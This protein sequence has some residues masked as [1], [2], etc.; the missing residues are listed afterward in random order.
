VLEIVFEFLGEESL[1]ES[2][3]VVEVPELARHHRFL[4]SYLAQHRRFALYRHGG[5]ITVLSVFATVLSAR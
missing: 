4:E 2:L 5:S 1:E 3:L